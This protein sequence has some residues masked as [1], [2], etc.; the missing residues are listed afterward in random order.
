V[1]G[2]WIGFS[3]AVETNLSQKR[4]FCVRPKKIIGEALANE[5]FEESEEVPDTEGRAIPGQTIVYKPSIE[6]WDNH[7]RTH[8]PF[9]KWCP[10]CVQGKCKSGAHMRTDKSDEEIEQEV[11]VISTDYMGP[12]SKDK[13]ESK[14][15]TSGSLPIIGGTDR[16][17]KWCFAHM[18]PKKGLD[19][20]AVAIMGREIKLSGYNRMILKSDQEPAIKELIEA[21]KRERD[22]N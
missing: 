20:H 3:Q 17:T 14:E 11:P 5:D 15:K 4:S 1:H 19:P 13:E 9:R 16:K 12:K 10:F 22:Q 6:E 21:V 7:M 18:V 2:M 8:L